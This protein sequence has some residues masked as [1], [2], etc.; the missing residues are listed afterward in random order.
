MA[1]SEFFCNEINF[2]GMVIKNGKITVNK[3]KI[4]KIIN[5]APPKNLR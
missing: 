1:K 5:L 2:L 4:K 3:D